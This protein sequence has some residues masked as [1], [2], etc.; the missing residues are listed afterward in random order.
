MA[1]NSESKFT[2]RRTYLVKIHSHANPGA[3]T[4]RIEN[5]VTGQQHEFE[6]SDELLASILNDLVQ[7]DER[8]ASQPTR[9]R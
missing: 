5:F 4:G 8:S 7:N 3:L 2:T 1:L 9:D 6:S